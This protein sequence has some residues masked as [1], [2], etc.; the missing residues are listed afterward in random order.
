[1]AAATTLTQGTLDLGTITTHALGTV[2]GAGTL[3]LSAPAS[4]TTVFPGGTFTSFL[5]AAGTGTVEYNS[6]VSYAVGT[7][8]LSYAYLKISG[9][10][11]KT[12]STSIT[13]AKDIT[14]SQG[15]TFNTASNILTLTGD[16]INDGTLTGTGT[17]NFNNTTAIQTISG[18]TVY[19]VLQ[20]NGKQG[21]RL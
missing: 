18:L 11:T 9:T 19:N 20:H 6:A 16:F 5:S 15:A 1:M 17:V 13:V 10:G 14:I 4:G 8:P 12:L 7:A 3:A 2:T 21:I